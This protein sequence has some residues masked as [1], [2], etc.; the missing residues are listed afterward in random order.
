MADSSMTK[1]LIGASRIKYEV[2]DQVFS[3]IKTSDYQGI[4]FYVDAHCI[5]HR[6]FR[7]KNLVNLYASNQDGMVR[8]L[9]VGFLN[10]LGHYRRYASRRMHLDNQIYAVF[11]REL[12]EYN[13]AQYPEFGQRIAQRYDT[14]NPDYGFMAESVEKAWNFIVGLSPYFEGIY[15]IDNHGVDDFAALVRIGGNFDD[16]ILHVIFSKSEYPL[17]LIR[18]NVVQLYNKRDNSYLITPKNCYSKGVLDGKVTEASDKL[19]PGMLPLLWT[20]G[21]CSSVSVRK[22]KYIR[23]ITAVITIANSMA[24]DG[25]L[26]DG[27]SIQSFLQDVGRWFPKG[28]LRVKVDEKF[29]IRRYR[30]LSIPLAAAAITSNQLAKIRSQIY[31]VYN[32]SE[33]EQLNELLS[34][35]RFDPDLLETTNLNMNRGFRFD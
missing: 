11:N 32:Q 16:D 23:G 26:Q 18:D 8:D 2:L 28:E 19:T 3:G 21:G 20:F 34:H 4:V 6:L 14:S 30:A 13:C 35:G 9:V 1:Y 15:C 27:I 5:F 31:D 10:V 29:L 22:L 33:L 17:Q 25:K 24:K 12:A 7:D